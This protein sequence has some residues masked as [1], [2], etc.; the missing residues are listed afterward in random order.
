MSHAHRL[1]EA[2][3]NPD[4]KKSKFGARAFLS[5]PQRRVD[6]LIKTMDTPLTPPFPE[7]QRV[8]STV[9]HP[10]G[11][12]SVGQ[13]GTVRRFL[14]S[15][16]GDRTDNLYLVRFD[17]EPYD[18]K[19]ANH[20]NL[21]P[22]DEG[23]AKDFVKSIG[24]AWPVKWHVIWADSSGEEHIFWSDRSVNFSGRYLGARTEHEVQ[25]MFQCYL[26]R[27]GQLGT[28]VRAYP[29]S[30]SPGSV[31][32]R[33]EGTAKDF[34]M[35]LGVSPMRQWIILWTDD[36][37][38]ET[39]VK[40]KSRGDQDQ[41]L[42]NFKKAMIVSATGYRSVSIH[43]GPVSEGKAKDF[44]MKCKT[45]PR[46]WDVTWTDGDGNFRQAL[47][48]SRARTE[49]D[50]VTDFVRIVRSYGERVLNVRHIE[51]W[52]PPLQN[53]GKARDDIM[54][55]VGPVRDW[56]VTCSFVR[57]SSLFGDTSEIARYLVKGKRTEGEALEA[58]K[59]IQ[60]V[61]MTVI[62]IRPWPEQRQEGKASEFIKAHP[63]EQHYVTVPAHEY[64]SRF[65]S[66]DG[67]FYVYADDPGGATRTYIGLILNKRVADGPGG[68]GW[69]PY[70][71]AVPRLGHATG[72]K[73]YRG[74]EVY[75][76]QRD[77]CKA[78]HKAYRGGV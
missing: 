9:N 4:P 7:G 16:S 26:D 64:S 30:C 29:V 39:M 41:V 36:N 37:G 77:A 17:N 5:D 35:S 75:A 76:S 51:P 25:M 78:L 71:I 19:Y 54:A 65:R 22:V 47:V 10:Y 55:C 45:Q 40:I 20:R 21:Q 74:Y 50:A 11:R 70:A 2:D 13:K 15:M 28:F 42:Q 63:P 24:K 6:V 58:F 66:V 38:L 44:I 31:S 53:E 69:R 62:S 32:T 14:G 68:P 8:R 12:Y 48:T 33:L 46:K 67:A 60:T 27:T 52:K 34:V 3:P 59:R 57:V 73:V 23:K 18:T 49:E 43:R 56:L 61:P 1:N 72:Y